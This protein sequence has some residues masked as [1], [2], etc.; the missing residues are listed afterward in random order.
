MKAKASLCRTFRLLAVFATALA[1]MPLATRQSLGQTGQAQIDRAVRDLRDADPS[2]RLDAIRA[3]AKLAPKQHAAD[4]AR[5]LSDDFTGVVSEALVTLADIGAKQYAG[6]IVGVLKGDAIYWI[7]RDAIVALRK[8][9]A[10]EYAKDMVPFLHPRDNESA[11]AG[12]AIDTLGALGAKQYAPNLV[13]LL[14]E[15]SGERSL[16]V[17][18]L[19]DWGASQYAAD[20]ARLLNDSDRGVRVVAAQTLAKLSAKDYGPAITRLLLIDEE[21]WVRQ[22]ATQSLR[23]LGYAPLAS[24]VYKIA[25]DAV[26]M[27]ETECDG[28]TA[29]G[30][31]FS[32]SVDGRI[33]TN[34]HVIEPEGLGAVQRITVRFHDGRI[35]GVAKTRKHPS[36]DLALIQIQNPPTKIL[37]LQFQQPLYVEEALPLI[38]EDLIMIGHPAGLAWSLSEGKV[39]QFRDDPGGGKNVWIQTDGAMNPGN[40]GG[41]MLNRYGQIVG[42][43]TQKLVRVGGNYVTGLNF[44]ISAPVARRFVFGS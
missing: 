44:G 29:T 13:Q 7:K 1:L 15:N 14:K 20:V 25:S 27:I 19:G 8:L 22:N 17:R 6:A 12:T 9:G 43:V 21:E 10:A 33:L 18:V 41:P 5:M 34:K 2:V 32:V 36:Y 37:Y 31:G 24:D 3:L 4:I 30:A 16:A 26:V 40:S 42:V 28:G 38:G 11:L 23:E 35:F 39:S